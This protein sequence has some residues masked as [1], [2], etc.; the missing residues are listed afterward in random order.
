M[1]DVVSLSFYSLQDFLILNSWR[2]VIY[3]VCDSPALSTDGRLREAPAKSGITGEV[4]SDLAICMQEMYWG[5]IC[6]FNGCR[7]SE[8][9]RARQRSLTMLQ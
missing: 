2:A 1:F 7:G 5:C 4:D 9:R 3:L 8:G 6:Q